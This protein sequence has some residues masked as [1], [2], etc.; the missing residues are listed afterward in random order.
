MYKR[1]IKASG[2]TDTLSG[3]DHYEYHSSMNGGAYTAP[4]TGASAL[5]RTTG[6]YT[7]QFRVFDKAGNS[8]AWAPGANSSANTACIR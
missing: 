6:T 2:S 5:F 3:I 8:T 4:A 7:V 1:Q